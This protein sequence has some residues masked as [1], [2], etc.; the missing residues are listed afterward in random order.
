MS[1]ELDLWFLSISSAL[2]IALVALLVVYHIQCGRLVKQFAA[3]DIRQSHVY[4][5]VFNELPVFM[6]LAIVLLVV[7]KPF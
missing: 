6:M 4:Y 2:V 7:L 5:R 3:G 1:H